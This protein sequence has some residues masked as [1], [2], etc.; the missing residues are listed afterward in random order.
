M[1]TCVGCSQEID[2][3]IA[4]CPRCGT[5]NPEAP[6]IPTPTEGA[7]GT[8]QI[9]VDELKVRLQRAL[10]RDFVVEHLLGEGGF[11]WVFAAQDR[12]LSRRIAV[13]VL[14][15]ELTASR[16]S[17][18]RF[19]REA[20][21]AASLSH[22]HVLAIFFV[23]EGEGL[24]FFG[25]PLVEGEALDALLA[26]EGQL[27]EAEVAR[28]GA[29]I[30]D[31]LAEAH[32]HG[33][34]HRDVKPA[35]VLLQ[36]A[37]RR[38]LVTD[39]GIA[40][41]AASKADKLTGT[42]VVIGT[43]HYMSPEQAGGSGEVDHRSDIYSLGVVLW[44][45]LAGSLPFDGPDSQ[46]I[47]VQHL[48]KD[49]PPVRSRRP[50]VSPGLA[51]IV[52]RCC[53][54]KLQDRF[55]S[56]AEVA[57][58]LRTGVVGAAPSQPRRRR[59]VVVAAAVAGVVIIAA[60]V[61]GTLVLRGT[62]S[63]S[64]GRPEAA[65]GDSARSAAPM[66]AVL[67]FDVNM[68]GDTA[69]LARQ[70]AR[71]VANRIASRFGVGTVDVNRLLGRWTSERRRVSAPLDSNAAFA[72]SMG[73]NQLVMGNAFEAGRQVRVGLD[74]YD[75][76]TYTGIG[77]YELDGSPEAFI[78]LLDQLA[79]S[80][81][82]AFCR[83]PEFNPRS[84]CFD[85]AAQPVVPLE[86]RYDAAGGQAPPSPSFYV[87]VTTDGGLA[88]QRIKGAASREVVSL[89]LAAV[90]AA[91]YRPA[92]KAGR[93]VEAWATVDVAV[94]AGTAA[95]ASVSAQCAAPT[96]GL[97]NANLECYE[98]RPS[99]TVPLLL[100][101]PVECGLAPTPATVIVRVSETGDVDMASTFSRSSCPAF[102]AMALAWARDI[103]FAPAQKGG[104]PVPAWIQVL[105]RPSSSSSGQGGNR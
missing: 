49:L 7:S 90:R 96:Y 85:V 41:A 84:L 10:G 53:A 43:P 89:A 94:R 100:S 59:Q 103:A 16:S 28:I 18:Q 74:V 13:K 72:Y 82:V 23:G 38:V 95:P 52:E 78:P 36:G 60:A 87:R 21:S 68:A 8:E 20:E 14:R 27:P 77:H 57:E 66:V 42:G 76:R 99:P 92:R 25:M 35:N 50:D 54:K 69:Q 12:K 4:Y 33:L 91:T 86:V 56:A 17:K 61:V 26:R 73:A 22:P 45:M 47:L 104:A 15:L 93:P 11:A 67:P 1:P 65:V 40:K 71:S 64:P 5:P 44:Q 31:A 62:G 63:R 58:A 32:G 81:A 70:S 3:S 39:F 98:T 79:E 46:G 97:R 102:T 83:Q 30:A 2:V 34:V 24:V 9:P 55:Q 19:V 80:L 51:R 75:T 29:E 88:D 105:I 101:A 37:K 6:T 48:T